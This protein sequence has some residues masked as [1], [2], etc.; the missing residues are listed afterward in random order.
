MAIATGLPRGTVSE[1]L[2]DLTPGLVLCSTA[3]PLD[4][5]PFLQS[6]DSV[7][8]WLTAALPL[9]LATGATES[10]PVCPAGLPVVKKVQ[11]SAKTSGNKK[12]PDKTPRK[13]SPKNNTAAAR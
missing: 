5:R 8:R 2:D 11:K 10:L 13:R 6:D 3:V 12:A 7:S 1:A 9:V 4:F